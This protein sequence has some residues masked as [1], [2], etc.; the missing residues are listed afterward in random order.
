MRYPPDGAESPSRPA[1]SPCLA[2]DLDS[3]GDVA[4]DPVQARDVARWRKAERE[5]LIWLRMSLPADER[6][7]LAA[8]IGRQL[9]A[10]LTGVERPVVSV[11]WPIRGEP[12]LRGWMTDAHARGVALALPVVVAPASPLE[13]RR[14]QPGCRMEHGVWRIPQPAER[15][16]VTPTVTV[17]PLVGYDPAC[18]R[19]G[20]GGGY[21]DR[22]LAS[23]APRPIVVGVG[24]EALA[25][26][27]IFP[28]A[29]DIPMDWILTGAPSRLSRR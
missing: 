15:I 13:F 3:R 16:L 5:R 27:T 6:D 11:Y 23:L 24:Y 1:S 28:Q 7:R 12:D 8:E 17:A 2:A 21:F 20:Y 22:T 4:A 26:A 10:I 18:Y 25:I 19:L 29:V 9:D 14:W